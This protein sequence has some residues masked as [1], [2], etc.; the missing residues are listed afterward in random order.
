MLIFNVFQ[1]RVGVDL[2]YNE[3]K[4]L[5]PNDNVRE[6]NSNGRVDKK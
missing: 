4:T 1:K 6:K 2:F 3:D 5:K